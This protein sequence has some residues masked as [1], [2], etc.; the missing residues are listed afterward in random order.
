MK[1]EPLLQWIQSLPPEIA[2]FIIFGHMLGQNINKSLAAV[3]LYAV[4]N[5]HV[6]VPKQK[7]LECSYSYMEGDRMHS[8]NEREKVNESAYCMAG[9]IKKIRGA[10]K[11]KKCNRHEGT[12]V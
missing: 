8:K 4:S 11:G 1:W 6:R 10:R 9:W 12:D 3:M 2:G 5:S 7:F